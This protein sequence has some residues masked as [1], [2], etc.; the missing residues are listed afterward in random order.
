MNYL[1]ILQPVSAIPNN[2]SV[3]MLEFEEFGNN[4]VT[5]Q[6]SYPLVNVSDPSILKG[7]ME[8][9]SIP[10]N[11]SFLSVDEVEPTVTILNTLNCS[12]LSLIISRVSNLC[13]LPMEKAKFLIVQLS[14]KGA[15]G[16]LSLYISG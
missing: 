11:K 14:I 1:P 12:K 15:C 16:P 7:W 2:P 9:G 5:A 13:P 6:A 10:D 4:L 8:N 3:W